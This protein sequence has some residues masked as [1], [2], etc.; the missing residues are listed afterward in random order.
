MNRFVVYS[1]LVGG[2]DTI[3]EP[4]VTDQRF[5][6]ILFTDKDYNDYNGIWDIRHIPIQDPEGWRQSRY[7]KCHPI[8]ILTNYDAS[9]Y[10]DANLQIVSKKIYDRFCELANSDVEWAGISHP[11]QACTYEE[12][13]AIVDLKWVH[14]YDVIDWYAKIKKEG[15]P[16]QWGLF[17]N[18]VIFRRHTQ[19]VIEIG[20]IWWESLT[21]FCKRDQF[22]L[23][24]ALW[25]VRPRLELF[26]PENEC[27]RLNSPYFNYYSHNPHTR[28][29]ALGINE[30]IRRRCLC[31]AYPNLRTG[32]HSLFNSLSKY[33]RPK[34]ML[35]IWEV[36]AI[37][38]YGF[39]VFFQTI[40]SRHK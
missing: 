27:P 26:L 37:A 28:I 8:A 21:H 7:V 20:D 31:V 1:S 4:L 18:N 5:D 38:R 2:Y 10:I 6:Y 35:Y 9:L 22:S 13:C 19:K 39:R 34:S 25:K 24:Y 14:D 36:Y 29:Q 17:E 11:S 3:R 15:F 33:N 23:M 12:I 32:L 16:E 40:L 30:R